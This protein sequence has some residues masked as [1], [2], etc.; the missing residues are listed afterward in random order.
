MISLS[1]TTKY[2]IFFSSNIEIHGEFQ[3]SHRL[4]AKQIL[5]YIK[6][7]MA[8]AVFTEQHFNSEN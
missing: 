4:A 1:F 6:G 5:K 8:T 2:R 3:V 7:I